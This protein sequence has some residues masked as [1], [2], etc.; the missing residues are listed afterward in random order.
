MI[1]WSAVPGVVAFLLL[2]A[3]LRGTRPGGSPGGRP[4]IDAGGR[5]FWAPVLLSPR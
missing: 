4:A 5:V 1:G 2:A 3:V